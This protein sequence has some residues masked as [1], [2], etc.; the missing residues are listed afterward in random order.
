[1][2]GEDVVENI[3][4]KVLEAAPALQTIKINSDQEVGNALALEAITTAL[5]HGALLNLQEVRLDGGPLEEE[6]FLDFLNVLE[7]SGCARRL[8]SLRV[9]EC[10]L[11]A[12]G[13]CALAGTIRRGGCLHWKS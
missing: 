3:S 13:V 2:F 5:R 12:D 6:R 4:C 10:K 7:C 9:S 11:G 1:M 8:K